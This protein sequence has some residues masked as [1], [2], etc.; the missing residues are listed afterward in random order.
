LPLQTVTIFSKTLDKI[1]AAAPDFLS[2]FNYAH[3]PTRFKTQ[4]QINDADRPSVDV[5]LN[6]LQTVG[7][8]L[9]ASGLCL[10]RYGS[11]CQ[12]Q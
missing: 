6:I 2:I 11:L 4:P 8:K 5:K 9:A 7:Q 1:L 3:M 12:T 10:Q